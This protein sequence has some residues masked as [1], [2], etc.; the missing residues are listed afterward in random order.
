METLNREVV[1]M[2]YDP[3]TKILHGE[4]RPLLHHPSASLGEILVHHL[5]K[6]PDRVAQV[7]A[8]E[9]TEV[10]CGEL[11]ALTVNFAK[12]LMKFGFKL[13]DVVG[14]L[15][16]SCPHA[17]PATFGC[18]LIGCKVNLLDSGLSVSEIVSVYQQTRPMIIFCDSD[19]HDYTKVIVNMLGGDVEIVTLTEH[20]DGVRHVA[21]FFKDPESKFIL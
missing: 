16:R 7:C 13:G 10:N 6:T 5:R 14:F 8:E 18:Y 15:G 11:A 1:E 21:E 2:F 3:D 12:N 20:L 17:I 9:G 19:F 4:Q